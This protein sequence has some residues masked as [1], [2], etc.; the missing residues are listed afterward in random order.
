MKLLV[1]SLVLLTLSGD[2]SED[3]YSFEMEWG[4]RTDWECQCVLD[5]Q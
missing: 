5:C 4:C 3:E 2:I 1:L